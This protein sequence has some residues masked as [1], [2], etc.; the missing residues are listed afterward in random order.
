MIGLKPISGSRSVAIVAVFAAL[1]T[2]LDS[3]PIHLF[4]GWAVYLEPLEGIILGPRLGILTA[5]I[6]GSVSR[7]V[8]GASMFSF[9][10]GV[11]GES[12]G[13]AVAG[14]LMK[15]RWRVVAAIYAFMLGAYFAHPYGTILPVWTILDCLVAFALV[16]PT[17]RLAK[18][19]LDRD[20]RIRW[21]ALAVMLLSFVSTV[22][23]SLVMVFILIPAGMHNV[24]FGTFEAVYY[25]FVVGAAGS[26]FEDAIAVVV[27]LVAYVP[28]LLFL[29]RSEIVPMPL[30]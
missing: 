7:G 21:V 19:V 29:R 23:H 27:S 20:T 10:Y 11:T 4:R 3:I 24:E 14:L 6:G 15:G 17:A 26:Y 18:N 1:H 8:A 2:I 5:V 28:L 13:V 22:A 9:I 12:V 30:S 25:A 16:Y